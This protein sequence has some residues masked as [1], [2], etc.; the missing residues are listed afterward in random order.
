MEHFLFVIFIVE[1]AGLIIL[2]RILFGTYLTPV[3]VLSVPY[4]IIV[5]LSITIGPD[6][7]FSNFYYPSLLVWMFGLLLFSFPGLVFATVFLQKTNIKYYPYE[8]YN[9][10]KSDK[11]ILKIVYFIILILVF[12]FF[13]IYGRYNIGSDD[14]QSVFGRGLSGHILL[15]SRFFFIYLVV[16]F[17]KKY[18]LPV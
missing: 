18:L 4:F 13:K 1:L 12:E 3:T 11:V 6:M 10:V 14:F 17:R 5:L 7:G 15:I 16:F 8:A 9:Q 2:E